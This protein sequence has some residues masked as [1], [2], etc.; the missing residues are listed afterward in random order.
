MIAEIK[1]SKAKGTLLA[2]PSKSMAHRLLICAALSNGKS[3]VKN[4]SLS[5]DIKATIDCLCALGAKFDINGE[6]ITVNG[7][8]PKSVKKPIYANCRESGSTLRFL[9]PIFF[10]T[11]I[12]CELT[13]SEYLFSRPLSVYEEISKRSG[14][15][16]SNNGKSITLK[17][18]LKSGEYI[19]PGNISSQFISGLLFAL[20][21]LEF[22]SKIIISGKFESKSYVDL[23]LN[24]LNLFGVKVEFISENEIFIKGNQ[25]YLPSNVTVEGDYSNTA[26]FEALNY[27]GSEIEII[28]LNSDSLQGDKRYIEYFKQLKDNTPVLDI[29]DCPDLA[30]ILFTLAAF[31]NGAKFIGTK[32]LTM[33]ESD[34]A[35]VMKEELSKFGADIEIFDNEVIVFK[36]ELHKP[37]EILDSHNDHRIAMSLAVLLTKFGGKISNAMAVKKSFP[38]FFKELSQLGIGVDLLED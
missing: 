5:E 14:F 2:P 26:F 27:L 33:K 7:I 6:V 34:R 25:N 31:F 19:I 1:V 23:T 38:L 4:I 11:N 28:G 8:N 22:D 12:K 20:P 29:T 13:G 32:R 35:T 16:F 30:P 36:N 9:I 18:N 21:T 24:A 3:V 37:C 17:G 15:V 10:L